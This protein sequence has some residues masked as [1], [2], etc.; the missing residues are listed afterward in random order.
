MH[1]LLIK[2]SAVQY[3]NYS[4]LPA[5]QDIKDIISDKHLTDVYLLG[6][7]HILPST[8]LMI[9]S[10]ISLGLDPHKLALIGKCYSTNKTVMQNMLDEGIFVCNSSVKF[11]SNLSFDEQFH[12]SVNLFLQTQIQRMQPKKDSTIIILDDGGELITCASQNL[13]KT[14]PNIFGVEQTASGSHKFLKTTLNFPVNNVALSK[15]KLEFESPLIAK[16][17]TDVLE[18][19]T[20]LS[21]AAHK[22]I[23]LI[24][25]GSIGGAIYDRIKL[26][27]KNQHNI[28]AYDAANEKSQMLYPDFSKFDLIIGATGTQSMSSHY[29][30]FLKKNSVLASVSSADREFDA[31]NFRKLSGKEWKTHDDVFY[32]GACLLNCGFPINFTGAPKVSVPLAKIQLVCTLLLLAVCELAC[33]PAKTS[34]LKLNE[35]KIDVILHKLA[36]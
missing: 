8:H 5:L 10:M 30:A 31:V 28:V 19:K 24:G 34:P 7:Q 3:G 13:A 20:S 12:Q 22:E 17:T 32:N 15:T 27:Y 11:N 23:L 16:A 14:Y 36:A 2:K 4:T 18:E 9:R 33:P 1:K 21:A 25:K 35:D 6:C 26:I 29:F